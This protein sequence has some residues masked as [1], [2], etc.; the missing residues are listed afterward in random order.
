MHVQI[1]HP[2]EKKGPNGFYLTLKL[3]F[4]NAF[5]EEL[6]SM[7]IPTKPTGNIQAKQNPGCLLYFP[8]PF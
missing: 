8:F 7:T 1:I 3:C 6:Q 5:K 2:W 4:I